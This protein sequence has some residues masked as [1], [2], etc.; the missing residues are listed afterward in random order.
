VLGR[1]PLRRLLPITSSSPPCSSGAPRRNYYAG[2]L[3]DFRETPDARFPGL[4]GAA[5]GVLGRA[6]AWV[7]ETLDFATEI[8]SDCA[9]TSA[10]NNSS[11]ISLL[12]ADGQLVLFTAD[13]GGPALGRAPAFAAAYGVDFVRTPLFLLQVPHHGSH[14]NLG[15]TV[16]GR[17][18]AEHAV[19]SAPPASDKHPSPKVVNALIRRGVRVCAT[20]GATLRY[21]VGVPPRAGWTDAPA[22][23]FTPAWQE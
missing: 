15:P 21:A 7:A 23:L 17:L 10:E 11:V 2:L 1:R 3:A 16:L 6:C 4:L 18:R 8:L 5:G 19:I 22:L 9:Q 20:R 13:A 14:R 12:A